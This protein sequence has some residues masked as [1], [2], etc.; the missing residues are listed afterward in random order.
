MSPESQRW[1]LM[2]LSFFIAFVLAIFPLPEILNWFRPEWVVLVLVYWIITLP[3]ATGLIMAWTV[4]LF[5][6]V[7]RGAL[8]GQNALALSL[9]TF[10]ALLLYSHLRSHTLLYQCGLIFLLVGM[11][12]LVLAWST[13]L[14]NGQSGEMGFLVPALCS[15]AAWP[16][17]KGF[18]DVTR[19]RL[20]AYS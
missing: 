18:M 17:L 12:Q 7:L 14:I 3:A 2:P 9:V 11:N 15:A 13:N 20:G 8:I 19:R 4:G 1:I 6:D 10:L 5:L 16:W